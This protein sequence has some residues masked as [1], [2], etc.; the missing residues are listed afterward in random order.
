MGETR[1]GISGW[2][3]PPWR[4]V[5][6]PPGLP[7]HRE[8]EYASRKFSTIEINGT[9]Y[10]L[11]RPESFERWY[12]DTPPNFVFSIK[13]A[14]Y[15]THIR[16]LRDVEGPLANFFASGIFNLRE[17]I[18]P[19]LWQF[20]PSFRYDAGRMKG[21]FE[22][23]PRDTKQALSLA[24]RREKRMTGR[25]RLAID[26]NRVL[27]HAIEIRHESF[28]DESFVQLLREH[29]IALV[30]AD[31]AGKWPYRE[32]ITADFL[33]LRLHGDKEIYASGYSPEALTRWS[34]RIHAWR[35]G[36]QPDDAHLIS[37]QPPPQR[38]SRDVYCYFDNDVK[39]KAPFDAQDLIAKL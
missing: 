20:P 37:T 1:I 25:A 4:G 2:R 16:R 22:I 33:Y 34:D 26:A 14:R 23:L 29:N 7:Q 8:L 12:Q 5:F 21:F 15:I 35:I 36:S 3:Y 9:F 19:I 18:G 13:G 27:R 6:Y 28:V 24:R 32:D 10:S 38:H 30:V 31:T 17:K 39:V 11:Q